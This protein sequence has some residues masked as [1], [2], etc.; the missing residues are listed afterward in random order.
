MNRL[1]F[2]SKKHPNFCNFRLTFR[3]HSA[4]NGGRI[5]IASC[6]LGGAQFAIEETI[7][8]VNDRKQ[9]N[10]RL[11]D[12]QNTQFQLAR[13]A[14]DLLCSRLLVREAAKFLD[15]AIESGENDLTPSLMSA[16]KLQ[17]T[18]KVL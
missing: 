11:I 8:Y 2:A 13:F 17:A 16:A 3:L 18:E 10:K 6:S 12:F 1:C 5:N 7:K 9:F 15:T 4:L 14:S